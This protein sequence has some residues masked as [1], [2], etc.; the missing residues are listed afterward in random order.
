[1]HTGAFFLLQQGFYAL[2]VCNLVALST[3]QRLTTDSVFPT[4]NLTDGTGQHLTA[5]QGLGRHRL[6]L[7]PCPHP[8]GQRV[9][10]LQGQRNAHVERMLP[11]M[12]PRFSFRVR[13]LLHI[14]RPRGKGATPSGLGLCRL[15]RRDQGGD[16]R[17]SPPFFQGQGQDNVRVAYMVL[18]VPPQRH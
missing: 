4:R 12:Q 18:A 5:V 13:G 3:R 16:R 2:H 17:G 14:E 10:C 7:G 15:P 6:G 8:P 11:C 1:M 9:C